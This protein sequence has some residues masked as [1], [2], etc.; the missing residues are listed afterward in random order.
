MEPPL[1]G[2]IKSME[3]KPQRRIV[4]GS[5]LEKRRKGR[6][7]LIWS[8][9]VEVRVKKTGIYQKLDTVNIKPKAKLQNQGKVGGGV[10]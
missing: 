7:K 9:G 8:N 3:S 2:L 6:P 5:L 10:L 4:T 1:N